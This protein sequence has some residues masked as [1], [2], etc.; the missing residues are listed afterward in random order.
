MF[1][2]S[3]IR[4]NLWG[5]RPRTGGRGHSTGIHQRP[6]GSEIIPEFVSWRTDWLPRERRIT[7]AVN[8]VL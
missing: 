8:G 3:R 6:I 1:D 5:C 4:T 2:E 7:G